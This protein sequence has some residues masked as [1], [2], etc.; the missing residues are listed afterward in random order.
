[1]TEENAEQKPQSGIKPDTHPR[2]LQIILLLVLVCLTLMV[3]GP[4]IGHQFLAYDDPVN[5][6]KNPFLQA[7]SLDNLLHFWRYPYEGLYAPL[8]YTAFA[9]TAWLP[10]MLTG[11]FTSAVIPKAWLFH[12]VNLVFHLLS[13]LIV[14]HMLRLLLCQTQSDDSGADAEHQTLPLEWAAGGG[15]L[16]FAIHP[17]Q[18]EAVAW[19]TGFKDV[20]F[21]F[22]SLM[23]LWLYLRYIVEKA[24]PVTGQS[25]RGRQ[26]YGLATAAFGMAL[27]AKPTAVVV[28]LIVWLLSLWGWQLSWREQIRGLLLWI[29]FSIAW[30]LLTRWIQP[31]TSLAFEPPVWARPLI[32]GDAVLFY[33]YKLILPLQFGPDYGRTPQ[34]MLEHG[35]IF[36]T[37]LIPFVLFGLLWLK[38]RKLSWLLTAFCL[39]I[40]GLLPVLGLISFA[41]QRHSTVADRY[42]YLAMLG[43]A[44][45]LAWGLAR[46]K[47]KIA[48]VCGTAVIGLFLLRSIW[49]VPVW[50]NTI[51]FFQ[52]AL[53][54]NPDSY[55]AH[56]NLGFALAEQGQD[57]QAI[58]HFTEALRLEPESAITY[59]NLGNAMDRQGKFE[60]AIHYYNEALRIV[61]NFA[62]AH[63]NLGLSLAKQGD[64]E[65]ALKHHREALRIEPRFAEAHHNLAN[66][67][68]RQGKFDIAEQHYT[69]ALRLNPGFA[70]GHSSYAVALAMQKRFEEAQHHFSEALR[71]QPNSANAHANLAGVL[72]QQMKLPE[73]ELHYREAIRLNPQYKNAHL[74]LST[75]LAAQGKFD[76][77]KHHISEVLRM[78]PDSPA[79]RQILERI[80]YL[81]RSQ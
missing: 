80:K 30:G 6:Y 17:L 65:K 19:V 35:W 48:I 56:S 20:L 71:L 34:H 16:L 4:V 69:E 60:A 47:K 7:R 24:T 75:V 27:L 23:A 14:W 72:L 66:V 55:L 46:A 36:L 81:E 29:A 76:G 73:A 50:Q 26:Y 37:G 53:T 57:D 41:F 38:R 59:L 2:R 43:P 40:V 21:G 32:A 77:A 15:A 49:L 68:A 61:P 33:L 63:T 1:M 28:P 39:F 54:V 52:H 42:V 62:R 11:N 25:L 79:A 45:A 64:Y 67:L 3:F 58:Q 31:G 8:I 22:L 10:G 9:L 5:V 51:V 12:S 44:L 70:K 18:V 13:V 78:D 74:R